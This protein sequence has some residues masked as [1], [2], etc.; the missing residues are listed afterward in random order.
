MREC[1]EFY[2]ECRV[3]QAPFIFAGNVNAVT[4][5]E[6]GD[7]TLLQDCSRLLVEMVVVAPPRGIETVV[8]TAFGLGQRLGYFVQDGFKGLDH[9]ISYFTGLLLEI[10]Q[11]GSAVY[12]QPPARLPLF[13]K[14]FERVDKVGEPLVVVIARC[15][16]FLKQP[17]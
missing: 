3:D 1:F 16:V 7:D 13:D 15:L 9:D 8:E 2:Q 14:R 5:A 17:D 11:R 4:L 10:T 12:A 6:K